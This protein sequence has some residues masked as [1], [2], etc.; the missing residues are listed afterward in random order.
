MNLFNMTEY[1]DDLYQKFINHVPYIYFV[2]K[3]SE[4][5]NWLSYLFQIYG[6]PSIGLTCSLFILRRVVGPILLITNQ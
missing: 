4:I 5:V 2:L 3:F 6:K 1:F